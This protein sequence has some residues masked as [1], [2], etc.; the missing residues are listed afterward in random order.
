MVRRMVT[1]LE[2]SRRVFP[3]PVA[4]VRNKTGRVFLL[5]TVT[6]EPAHVC[7]FSVVYFLRQVFRDDDNN[8]LKG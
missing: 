7:V 1:T 5:L 8:V 6:V 4:T 3:L 2:L